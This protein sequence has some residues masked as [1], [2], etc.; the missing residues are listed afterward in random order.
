MDQK[1]ALIKSIVAR[2]KREN[3]R[4]ERQLQRRLREARSFAASIPSA[5]RKVD[6]AVRKIVLCCMKQN[7]DQIRALSGLLDNDFV[8]RAA[9]DSVA[10]KLD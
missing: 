9:L 7:A 10:D 1:D 2:Q 8:R 3:A 4:H 6:P 5:F